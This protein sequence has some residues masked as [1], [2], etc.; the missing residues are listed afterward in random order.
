MSPADVARILDEMG[1][2]LELRGE[3]P[4]RCRAY[5]NAADAIRGLGDDLPE[6]IA[7]GR[8]AEVPGI[9][10]TIRAKVVQLVT[11]GSVPLYDELRAELPPGLVALLRV[12]GLGPKKIKALHD[13]LKVESLADLR[14]AAESG[15]IAGLKGFG[16]KT[17]QK[18]LEGLGFVESTGDRILQS[19]ARR[20]VS[21]ILGAVRSHPG[22]IEAEAC[23][24]LRRRLDTIGDLDILFSSDDPAPVL[25]RFVSLPE[26]AS[27][28]A[29]GPTKASVRLAG[30][31]QCDL[32]GVSPGQ[33]PFALH[34]FT[35]SKAHNIAMRRRAIARGLRLN[36]YALEGP[37]G[38]IPCGSEEELFRALGLHAIPPELREDRGEFD[39]AEAGPI[40]PLVERGDLRGTFHCH[41]DWSDGGNTLAEMAEAARDRGL[42]YLGIADHSR[43]AAYAGGLSIDRVRRQWEAIDELNA[44]MGP[45]FRVFKGIEC[46]ILADG[47]LDYPDDV[48]EG[49]DYVV[50]SV[51]SSFGLPA[52][53]MTA[54][55]VRAVR[56]P[57]VTML[58]HPTGRLLLR[59]EAYAV[60]LGA[61]IEAAAEAGTMIE[62][63]ASPHR[64]DLDAPHVRRAR[65]RGVAI[66]IN[67]D[68]HATGGLD[69]LDYG[70]GVARRA[71]LGAAEVFNSLPAE[72]ASRAL[73]KLRTRG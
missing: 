3:N 16:A 14:L 2:L 50:A 66:V 63:N 61:V 67:P 73:T 71:G 19:T 52:E 20:L 7:S 33:F 10:E 13:A 43:S 41:T 25:D 11:T 12:P 17:E 26:V 54:R 38:P 21:P 70:V 72:E 39:R 65:D 30:G 48:L 34:Y 4:F 18:I 60:D 56:H 24:S 40:P 47:S 62:I 51:H 32:R 55:I 23:G 69:D 49:F 37:D 68:A 9:G 36:E 42:S 44:A 58:G 1:T 53:A 35:G 59:R 15:K 27:V 22:V 46:D 5:H 64:L 31:V 28:L 45:A 57:L 6:R 29:H 8:L